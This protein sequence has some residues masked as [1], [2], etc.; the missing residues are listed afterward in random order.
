MSYCVVVH[1]CSIFSNSVSYIFSFFF[2]TWVSLTWNS[3]F[4]PGW[5]WTHGSLPVS[6]SF[7]IAR[8]KC[9]CHYT[10]IFFFFF[11]FWVCL[12]LTLN[13]HEW[14]L[15]TFWI[16]HWPLHYPC[17][18]HYS[19]TGLQFGLS[20]LTLSAVIKQMTSCRSILFLPDST[21]FIPA[22]WR[23]LIDLYITELL[24]K[25]AYLPKILFRLHF[26]A[27]LSVCA[28]TLYF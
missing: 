7:P 23:V 16:Q 19:R 18:T 15:I 6:A 13:S 28:D 20:A 1:K 3:L 24:L 9:L 4:R 2:N 12:N 25:I 11:S 22:K 26:A 21:S 14:I 17:S 8:I 5:P 10:L 27:A